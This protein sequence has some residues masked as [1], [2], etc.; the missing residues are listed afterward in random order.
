MSKKNALVITPL[1]QGV[2][3]PDCEVANE[4]LSEKS[5]GRCRSSF[6]RDST[7]DVEETEEVTLSG[8]DYDRALD[9][10][11]AS[12]RDD[13]EAENES[14]IEEETE[15]CEEETEEARKEAEKE[16]RLVSLDHL[17]G[18]A[19]VKA[20]LTVYEKLVR[21]NK[22]RADNGFPVAAAPLHAMFLG[23]PGTGKTTVAKMMGV[24][25]RRAGVLSSGH[26]VVRERSRLLGPNYR[27]CL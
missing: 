4:K 13:S 24:M 19:S 3:T 15:D 27:I 10:F 17:T 20:K 26:L 23:S 25:L 2:Y 16:A 22:M 21:F 6:F 1:R 12:A 14:E 5:T 9:A 11:I 7:E 8:D 18:L